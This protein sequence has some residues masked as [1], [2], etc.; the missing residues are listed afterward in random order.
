[1]KILPT[2]EIFFGNGILQSLPSMLKKLNAAS[3]LLVTDSGIVRAG[4]SARVCDLLA[5]A[6]I[7]VTAFTE[8][9]A[10]PSIRQ[11]NEVVALVR[12][13]AFD[14]V[15]GLGGG[16][17]IDVAKVSAAL[18][19]NCRP[20]DSY[21]GT[22]LLEQPALPIIAI[23]TT[24]GTGS[25][26]TPIAILSDTNA[27]LKKGIVSNALIPR[28]AFLD[29]TLTVSLPPKITAV[30]GMDALCH[31]IEAY[32]SLNATPYSDPLAIRAIEL[33]SANLREAFSNGGNLLARGNMLL[34]SLLAGIAF[35]NAGVTAVHAFA[36]PLGGRYHVPHG[37]ANSMMLPAIVEYNLLGNEGRF[38]D[39]AAAMTRGGLLEGSPSAN[40]VVTGVLA[41]SAHLQIP[42]NLAELG[43]PAAAVPEMAEGAMQGTRLLANNPRPITLDD[44]VTLYS[45]AMTMGNTRGAQ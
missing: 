34:G 26:V 24:A 8:V 25:E 45:R 40:G 14:A 5:A 16:S 18:V 4:I 23:P 17:S 39:V 1:M 37:L 13:Q 22:D 44:A 2:P 19:K 27:Q 28:Y 36:Y 11:V 32:T 7:Q 42:R 31:A 38:T 43:I 30:T 6:G 12:G 9:E 3:V 29:A 15:I 20:I 10:D 33:I 41:L 35:A 21:F